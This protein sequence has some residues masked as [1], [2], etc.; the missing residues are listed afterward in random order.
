MQTNELL[1]NY[2]NLYWF[3]APV[4]LPLVEWTA[5]GTL[6]RG[7]GVGILLDIHPRRLLPAANRGFVF[8]LRHKTRAT[9]VYKEEVRKLLLL[10][11]AAVVLAAFVGLASTRA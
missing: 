4:G 2:R 9:S 7:A 5:A 1:G 6:R 11:G 3:G 8:G 10:N